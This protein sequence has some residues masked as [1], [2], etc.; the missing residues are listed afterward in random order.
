MLPLGAREGDDSDFLPPHVQRRLDRAQW[1]SKTQ[2]DDRR[3]AFAAEPSS[4]KGSKKTPDGVKNFFQGL[5]QC[6]WCGMTMAE[7]LQK[8]GQPLSCA[9]VVVE[10]SSRNNALSFS[11][12]SN[13]KTFKN[14][15]QVRNIRNFLYLCGT[16]SAKGSCHWAQEELHVRCLYDPLRKTW[17]LESR[18]DRWHAHSTLHAQQPVA[19]KLQPYRRVMAWHAKLVL[20]NHWSDDD[21]TNAAIA[22]A[23]FSEESSEAAEEGTTP[24]TDV[25]SRGVGTDSV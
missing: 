24:T 3:K 21:A 8:W 12:S 4:G 7:S 15:L 10:S 1:L 18:D 16:K 2:A 19:L 5:L 25:K 14:E 22:A 20:I 23:D 13:G 11:K 6:E 9:H 17:S